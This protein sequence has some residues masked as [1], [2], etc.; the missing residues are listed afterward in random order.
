MP[1]SNFQFELRTQVNIPSYEGCRGLIVSRGED[2]DF[3][4][5]YTI[6]WIDHRGRPSTH[7]CWEAELLAAN[8][9]ALPVVGDTV[10]VKNKKHV[11]TGTTV[12]DPRTKRFKHRSKLATRKNRSTKRKK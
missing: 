2:M 8:A 11:V 1:K 7:G 10:L 6:A 9:P 12:F 3:G 5:C 4:R